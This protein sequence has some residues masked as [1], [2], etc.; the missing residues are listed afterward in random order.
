LHEKLKEAESYS[1][2]AP[3]RILRDIRLEALLRLEEHLW[4][5]PGI[6]VVVEK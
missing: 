2:Y 6:D 5:L 3:T 1:R 4:Q